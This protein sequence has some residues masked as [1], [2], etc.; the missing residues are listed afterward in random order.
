MPEIADWIKKIIA[1]LVLAGFLEMILPSNEL[2]GV[3]K[4]MIGLLIILIIVQPLLKIFK[5]PNIILNSAPVAVE[6]GIP[7]MDFQGTGRIIKEG[8]AIRTGLTAELQ[9]RNQEIFIEKIKI[10]VRLIDEVTLVDLKT[11]FNDPG[12]SGASGSTGK[13]GMTGYATLEKIELRVK[14]S[15]SGARR[16]LSSSMLRREQ[17][18]LGQRIRDTV[19]L[20][21]NLTDNQ[22]EVIWDG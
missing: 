14:L 18:R 4:M 7:G 17:Q 5:L 15:D 13:T 2:K 19:K 10:S 3:T 22:I 16:R 11:I 9:K 1:I 21:S 12:L 20:F 6:A 8:L